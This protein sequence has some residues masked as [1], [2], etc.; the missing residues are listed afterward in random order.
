M[1]GSSS[2][3]T[4]SSDQLVDE[5]KTKRMVSNRESARRSRMRKQKLMDDLL[6]QVSQLRNENNRVMADVSI[7]MQHY[8]NVEAENSV[9]R[10]RVVELG[11]RLESL[12]QIIAVMNQPVCV[13]EPAYDA[14]FI[15]E[16]MDNSLTCYSY[17]ANQ[18]IL[19]S[20][21]MIQY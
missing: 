9:L 15:D 18:S 10:A 11:H 20:A 1:M 8:G 14:E 21:D 13:D 5:R 4:T 3:T 17:Y 16:F 12:N 6:T 2:G 7:T 19:A